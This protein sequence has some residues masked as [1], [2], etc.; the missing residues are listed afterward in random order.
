MPIGVS[1]AHQDVTAGTIGCQVFQ[2]SGCHVDVFVLSNNHVLAD[3]N[4]ALIGDPILQPGPVDGGVLPG[5]QIGI[6]SQYEPVVLSTSASNVMDAAIAF[7][8]YNNSNYMTPPD[9][10]GAPRN[11]VVNPTVNLA[12][13][14]YGRTTRTTTGRVTS[15]NATIQVDYTGGTAQFIQQMVITGDNNAPFTQGGDSGSLVVVASGANA[16]KAV[17]LVFAGAGNISAANPMGPILQRFGV[18]IS[19]DL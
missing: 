8:D 16:R 11:S 3:S 2:S 18:Q 5:D 14:K 6:L 12:V 17:G 13:R 1:V 9:G 19:G 4:Q 15:I 7:T 10:Y